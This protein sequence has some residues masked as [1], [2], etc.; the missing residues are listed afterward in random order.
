MMN[1]FDTIFTLL[2]TLLVPILSMR[3]ERHPRIPGFF[4]AVVLCYVIGI[5]L[6]NTVVDWVDTHTA[7]LLA[8]VSMM[9]ALPMLLFGTNIKER[10]G[11]WQATGLWAF[12]LC[13]LSGL[14]SGFVAWLF[15][16]SQKMS[17]YWQVC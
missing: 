12:V 16:A 2:A 11:D 4:S 9:I 1:H 7:E 13:A 17:G 10:T 15:R 8:G 3:L 14:M 6:G 5:V